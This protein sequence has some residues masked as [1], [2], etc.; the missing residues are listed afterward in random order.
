ME[1]K[2]VKFTYK[3]NK[4]YKTVFLAGDFTNWQD[5][6]VMMKKGK[7]NTWFALAPLNKGEHEYKFIVDGQWMTDPSAS[8]KPNNIGSENS[9]I[10][11][12]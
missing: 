11:V 10:N 12:D 8:R 1:N 9:I 7:G 3:S 4:D 6:P 2:M 5:N